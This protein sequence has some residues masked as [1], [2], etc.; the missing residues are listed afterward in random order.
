MA[1]LKVELHHGV[2]A[3]PDDVWFG[4][5]QGVVEEEQVAQ[6][7]HS[8]SYGNHREISPELHF[9]TVEIIQ[10]ILDHFHTV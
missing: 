4:A 1:P 2:T 8:A 6:L 7:P 5:D 3:D 10:G 9:R